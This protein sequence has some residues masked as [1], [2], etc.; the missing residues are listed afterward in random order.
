MV[1][2]AE[3]ALGTAPLAGGALLGAL[4]GGLKGPDYRAQLKAD[5]DLLDRVEPGE[6]RDALQRCIDSRIDDLIDAETRGRALRQ[7]VASYGGGWRDTVMFA[8]VILFAVIWWHVNHDRSNWVVVFVALIVLV[9]AS[10]FVV[11]REALGGVRRVSGRWRPGT[12][13][14]PRRDVS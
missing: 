2:I 13:T 10:G 8:G 3:F 4:A 9:A 14:L 5:L 7:S 11:V 12:S 1:G 6:R